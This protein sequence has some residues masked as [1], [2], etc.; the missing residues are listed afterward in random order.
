MLSQLSSRCA[1]FPTLYLPPAYFDFSLFVCSLCFVCSKV[2]L[3]SP[4][5]PRIHRALPASASQVPRIKGVHCNTELHLHFHLMALL[6]RQG[7]AMLP[8]VVS[9]L[10]PQPPEDWEYNDK[11]QSQSFS[12][13]FANSPARYLNLTEHSSCRPE[14]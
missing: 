5:W 6:L 12:L 3:C 2:S 7:L 4:G 1:A 9:L 10:L 8:K 11:P 13:I 14:V